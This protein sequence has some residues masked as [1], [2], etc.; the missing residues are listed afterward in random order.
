MVPKKEKLLSAEIALRS[1]SGK[2]FDRET[3]ITSQNIADYL[4]ASEVVEEA[5]R[6]FA[7][8]GFQVSKAAGIGFSITGPARLFK[9]V[10]KVKT[11]SDG[12]GGVKV[13]AAGAG[14]GSYELP[15]KGLPTE[16]A[17]HVVVATFSPPPD[18]GPGSF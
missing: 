11:V 2:S 3:K 12:R 4:P 9:K 15:L 6:A 7:K 5:R 1:A 13:L 14:E 8:A 16:L 10:F 17:Q 18:F